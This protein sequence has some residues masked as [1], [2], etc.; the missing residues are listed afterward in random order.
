MPLLF[1][2]RVLSGRGAF[3]TTKIPKD[4][5]LT[6]YEGEILDTKGYFARFGHVFGALLQLAVRRS[7]RRR[8]FRV[9]GSS[10]FAAFL[11]AEGD[12]GGNPS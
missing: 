5:L 12:A 4:T 2:L 11:F 7:L 3:A 8:S 1:F 10:K 6:A 9:F